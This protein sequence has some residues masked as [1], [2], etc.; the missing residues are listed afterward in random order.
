MNTEQET[1][2]QEKQDLFPDFEVLLEDVEMPEDKEETQDLDLDLEDDDIEEEEDAPE[3]GEEA[4]DT[5][6]GVFKT[7]QEKEILFLD[8]EEKFDGTWDSL[9]KHIDKLPEQI[10]STIIQNM[11]E[12]LQKLMD[13]GMT[14]GDVSF[15]DLKEFF[16]LQKEDVD[17]SNLDFETIEDAR[18]YLSKIMQKQNYDP[19]VIDTTLDA[20]EDKGEDYIKNKAKGFAEKQ[21]TQ[22]A[23]QRLQ[24]E[25]L[26]R[27]QLIQRQNQFFT[28]I[29][30]EL[31]T[32]NYSNQRNQ[33]IKSNLNPQVIAQ[34]N[35][36]IQG[37]PKAIIQLADFYSYFDEK[38][39]E[40][41]LA[42]FA[43]M[44]SSKEVKKMKEK[45]ISNNFSSSGAKNKSKRHINNSSK[46]D[47]F[48]PVF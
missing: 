18:S 19:D 24:Q 37:S 43:K 44:A 13:Y 26:E 34:K 8:D 2:E 23:D 40:F 35:A 22:K 33:A 42:A 3:Y 38:S 14:K 25:K 47:D 15:E 4:D 31:S 6:I 16:D 17:S 29:N 11:P 39:G 12:P 21:Q 36:S 27:D 48:E 45:L 1:L 30:N 5:A 9:E 7:L 46:G 20:M 10:A 28:N 41:N 32:L